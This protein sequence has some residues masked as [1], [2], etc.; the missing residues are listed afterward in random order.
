VHEIK[1]LESYLRINLLGLG[2]RLIKKYLPGRGLT[3]V[4][5]HWSKACA[6][7]SS[8][9]FIFHVGG[10]LVVTTNTS[11][12]HLLFQKLL[13]PTDKGSHQLFYLTLVRKSMHCLLKL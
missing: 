12:A 1:N 11:V 8:R 9:L 13:Y 5:K 6:V 10:L 4:E 3:K 2:P 7:T